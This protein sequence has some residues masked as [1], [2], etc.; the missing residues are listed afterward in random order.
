M[1]G[2]ERVKAELMIHAISRDFFGYGS[3]INKQSNGRYKA[4]VDGEVYTYSLRQ[5]SQDWDT[6]DPVEQQEICEDYFKTL[7]TVNK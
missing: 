7:I 6:L 2:K 1:T 3:L 4:I 5:L